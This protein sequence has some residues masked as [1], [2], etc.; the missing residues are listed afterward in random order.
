MTKTKIDW[1]DE[2]WSPEPRSL[3]EIRDAEAELY[4]KVWYD[5]HQV[6]M[7]RVRSGEHELTEPLRKGEEAARRIEAARGLDALGPYDDFEWGML[8]GKL[9]ALRWVLG[10]EWDITDS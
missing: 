9:S 8:S 7:E 2:T 4:E 1:T 5:R 3:D 10:D 6:N